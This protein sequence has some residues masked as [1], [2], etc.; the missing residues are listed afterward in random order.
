MLGVL[1]CRVLERSDKERGKILLI[2]SV[3]RALLVDVDPSSMLD[4][5]INATKY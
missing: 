4:S 2:K 3:G 5:S 1:T